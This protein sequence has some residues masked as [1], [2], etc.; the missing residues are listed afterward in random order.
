M[1]LVI[2]QSGKKSKNL[3]G[4]V[5]MTELAK[6]HKTFDEYVMEDRCDVPGQM[7]NWQKRTKPDRKGENGIYGERSHKG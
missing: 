4:T 5:R 7:A 6:D 2:S 3:T 1:S